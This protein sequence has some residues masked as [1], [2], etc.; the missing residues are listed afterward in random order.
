[1]G[2]WISQKT[3]LENSTSFD[4]YDIPVTG[5][6]KSYVLKT[7]EKFE[8]FTEAKIARDEIKSKQPVG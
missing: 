7:A 6:G 2:G 4:A 8:N 5:C 3:F 1:M